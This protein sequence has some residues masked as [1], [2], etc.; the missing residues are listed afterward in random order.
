M[1]STA[2]HF[3]R[4]LLSVLA[5]SYVAG[6]TQQAPNDLDATPAATPTDSGAAEV[7]A[8]T[9]SEIDV[10]ILD[11]E[12][13][14][15]LRESKKG[16]V[17][18][19]DCWST[20]CVPCMK[21]FHHLVEIHNQYGA[22]KVACMSLSFDFD[23]LGDSKPDDKREKVLEFLVA[24]K[25]SFDN[26]LSSTP[27]EELYRSL[28]IGSIP[29]IFVFDAEGNQVQKIEGEENPY[30]QVRATVDQLINAGS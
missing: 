21:E 24:Q 6:C 10:Q 19:V 2:F 27:D 15:K 18:V 9:P 3:C 4:V 8:S 28:E 29:A 25:A 13:F 17:V 26:V 16:K 14:Q 12:G 20:W 1:S 23:G 7:G 22:D 11:F 5:L 30:V